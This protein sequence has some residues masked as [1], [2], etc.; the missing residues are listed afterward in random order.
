MRSRRRISI[1]STTLT[2]VVILILSLPATAGAV[3]ADEPLT[4]ISGITP[5]QLEAEL[6]SVNP[7]HI[8]PDIA[9]LYVTWGY[10]FGIRADLAFAQMLHETDFLRYGGDVQP[11]QNNF[12]GIGATGGGNPGNSFATTEAGV[13]AHYAHLAWYVYPDHQNPYCNSA[14][15]PRHFGGGHRNTVQSVRD[16]GGQWAVPGDGYGEAIADYA[17]RFRNYTPAGNWM[18]SFNEITGIPDDD[19]STN[20]LFPWYDSLPQNGMLNNWILIGNAGSGEARVEIYIGEVRMRDHGND[21]SDYFLIPEGGQISPSFPGYMGGP[22]RVICTTGQPLFASQRVLFRDSFNEVVGVPAGR[23]SDSYLFTWY[24]SL[25]QNGM[26]GNWILISNQGSM[27]ADVEVW[28]GGVLRAEYKA[29]RG[30]ALAAGAIV[31]PS[32]PGLMSGPVLVRSTNGQPLLA[33]QRVLFR[34]SFN[35][36][37]GYP[38]DELSSEYLFT[39]YDS[40]RNSGI[41]GNWVLVANHGGVPADVDIYVGTRL[42]A[43]FSRAGG[44]PIPAGG[45]VAPRFQQLTGGPVRVVSSN[46]QPLQASQRIIFRDS[47]EEVQGVAAADLSGSLRFPWYDSMLINYMKGNWLLIGNHGSGDAVIEISIGG[48]RMRDPDSPRNDYFVIPEGGLKTL[49]FH[50]TMGGPVQVTCVTGQPLLVSQRVLYKDGL[51][52]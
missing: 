7:G 45:M 23:L 43:R 35:E 2:A 30:N 46:G 13:I 25:P 28:I 41:M 18:G 50:N 9:Q 39:W 44:N 33:S 26:A 49:Q 17:T 38:T 40:D 8:N 19:L 11:W 15:D 21:D 27:A 16:L 42:L 32:F 47:L 5:A 20:L 12:A 24:D 48:R 34:E 31:T 29:S 52:R 36:V 3:S 22:V 4:G 37:S 14:Y 10:R 6:G 51:V 1:L